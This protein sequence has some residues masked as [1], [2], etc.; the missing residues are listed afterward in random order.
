M[1]TRGTHTAPKIRRTCTRA[2]IA[3][4]LTATTAYAEITFLNTWGTEGNGV[5]QFQN[6]GDIALY[7]SN[8]WVYVVDSG[9]LRVQKF[10]LLGNFL[11]NW[12][13]QGT[14]NG[15]FL[16]PGNIEVGASGLVYVADMETHRVQKFDSQGTFLG[17]AVTNGE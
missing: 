10:D 12:G 15:Q 16:Q 17:E 13:I 3:A 6:P 7:A 2:L 4:A 8:G 1:A 14:G 5:G 9:N 11:L